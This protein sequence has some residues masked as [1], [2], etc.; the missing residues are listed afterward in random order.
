[1]GTCAMFAQDC[2]VSIC[3]KRQYAEMQLWGR[4]GRLALADIRSAVSLGQKAVKMDD[5]TCAA[6]ELLKHKLVSGRPRTLNIS[7]KRK[8]VVVFTD[9]SLE[10]EGGKPVARIVGCV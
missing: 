7:R 5:R 9:G 2:P 4:A 1:M 3:G 6:V 8:P 10:Y